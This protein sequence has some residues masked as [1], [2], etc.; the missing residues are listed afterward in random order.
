[1]RMEWSKLCLESIKIREQREFGSHNF[2]TV[3]TS[4][5]VREREAMQVFV[6]WKKENE[7]YWEKSIVQIGV[8]FLLLNYYFHA[9]N[10]YCMGGSLLKM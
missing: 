1:M 3:R 10:I 6:E 8:F 2:F 5:E 4:I 9:Q 7:L